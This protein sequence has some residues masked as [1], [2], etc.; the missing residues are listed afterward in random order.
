MYRKSISKQSV[1]IVEQLQWRSTWATTLLDQILSKMYCSHSTGRP[2]PFYSQF[3]PTAR[4]GNIF[5]P[6]WA[7]PPRQT[8][9]PLGSTPPP[10]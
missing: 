10:P 7:D 9:F 5:T 4:E 8:P 1:S 3:L 6:G 2:S